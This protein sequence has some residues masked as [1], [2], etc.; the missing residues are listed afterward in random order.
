MIKNIFKTAFVVILFLSLSSVAFAQSTKDR[1]RC[2]HVVKGLK[3]DK[4][5]SAKFSPVFY[6]YLKDLHQA[7]DL[8]DNMKDKY[9]TQIDKHQLTLEQAQQLLDAHWN[10]DAKQVQVK[11][12]YTQLFSKIIKLPYVYYAFKLSNDKAPK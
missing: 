7:G 8:Y 12:K 9:K 6:A 5:L 2:Q 3:L 1:W 11:Q 10:S 4:E